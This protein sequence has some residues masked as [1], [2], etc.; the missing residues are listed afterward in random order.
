[1][2]ARR[3]IQ[4]NVRQADAF[5]SLLDGCK[6]PDASGLGIRRTLDYARREE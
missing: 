1:M 3:N 6:S 2:V 4:L 5:I